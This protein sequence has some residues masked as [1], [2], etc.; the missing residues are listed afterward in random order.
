M[1]DEQATTQ[2]SPARGERRWIGYAAGVAI[3]VGILVAVVMP[4]PADKVLFMRIE[5]A[6]R[7]ARLCSH[8]VAEFAAAGRRWPADASVVGCEPTARG[9]AE[10][11]SE[12]GAIF[13][14][15]RGGSPLGGALIRLD[16]F[17]DDAGL[18]AAT[19]G[20]PIRSWKCSSADPEVQKRLPKSCRRDAR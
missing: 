20:E 11:R 2:A 10:L 17:Q 8:R 9:V 6:V 15:L 7:E 18:N 3:V 13:V 1:A 14:R 16:P 19:A 5:D 12:R 4:A